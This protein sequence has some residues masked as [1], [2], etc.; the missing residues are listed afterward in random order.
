MAED[1]VAGAGAEGVIELGE[2]ATLDLVVR[3][4]LVYVRCAEYR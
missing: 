2:D 4:R 3:R 1:F